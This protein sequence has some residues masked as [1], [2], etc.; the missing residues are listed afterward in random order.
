MKSLLAFAI[1]LFAQPALAAVPDPTKSHADPVLVGN[2]SGADM[3][4]AF[5]VNVRDVGNVPKPG[6]TVSIVF[7]A[8]S[9]SRPFLE[10]EAGTSVTCGSPASISR[11]TDSH[12]DVTFHAAVAVSDDQGT[13]QVRANGVLLRGIT[14]RSTDLDGDGDTDLGDLN[15][16]RVQYLVDPRGAETDYNQDGITDLADFQLF[17]TEYFSG[18]HNTICP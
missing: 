11:V 1:L 2:V 12:G 8:G 3:G 4:N 14:I 5:H 18:A 17:R 15:A 9:R 16:F 6:V 7:F 13:Y 10:Q